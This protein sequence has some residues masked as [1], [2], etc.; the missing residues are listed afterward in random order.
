M[1]VEPKV[2]LVAS[3]KVY[4]ENGTVNGLMETDPDATDAENLIEAA[5]RVCYNS[6]HKPNP[7]TAKNANYIRRTCFEQQHGSVMEHATAT[8]SI[9]GVSRAWLA[10][11][12]RHRPFSFSVRSQRFVNEQ[13]MGIVL[14]PAIREHGGEGHL[15]QV[16][17]DLVGDYTHLVDYLSN[18]GLPRKQAREAARAVLPNMTET[19]LY[20]SGNL[21]AWVQFLE[22]RL[23][24]SAD[25]EM[26][27]VAGLILAALRPVSPV[28]FGEVKCFG[29]ETDTGV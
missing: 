6:E 17:A 25:A 5:G 18:A 26:R 22:R 15:E 27:R 9:E 10:E 16:A 19:K 21:R 14:P 12:T 20:M 11:A 3:T 29:M 1:I 24:P 8:V 28:V 7:Q 2:K 4:Y 23:D 13:D